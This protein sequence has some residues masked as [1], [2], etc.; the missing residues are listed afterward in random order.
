VILLKGDSL[1]VLADVIGFFAVHLRT[2]AWGPKATALRVF[3]MSR[4]AP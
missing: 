1:S 3:W 4:P 2:T